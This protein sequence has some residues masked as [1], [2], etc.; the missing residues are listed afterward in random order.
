MGGSTFDPNMYRSSA[1][2]S[3]ASLGKSTRSTASTS[4]AK[5]NTIV[6]RLQ[7]GHKNKAGKITRES[8]DSDDKPETVAVAVFVDV[9]GSNKTIADSALKYL[10]TLMATLTLE[11][12]IPG[13]HVLFGAVDDYKYI[14]NR[15]LQIGQFEGGLEVASDLSDLV[16][17]AMGGGNDV[18]SYELPMYFMAKYAEMD[19]YEKRGKKGYFFMIADE[20]LPSKLNHHEW[21]EL[22]GFGADDPGRLHEDI[23]IKQVAEM[24]QEK[25]TVCIIYPTENEYFRTMPSFI[26]SWRDVFGEAVYECDKVVGIVPFITGLIG[27]HEG[28]TVAEITAKMKTSDGG[29][30]AAIDAAHTSLTKYEAQIGKSGTQVQKWDVSDPDVLAQTK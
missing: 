15:A 21:N 14:R 13:P 8:R 16:I 7:A 29:A 2:Y 4:A 20:G 5:S 10:P 12:V 28:L 27:M 25:F 3:A 17:T 30:T 19:C 26:Q 11:K 18:E 22:M 1:L 6:D 9:T 23:P 24:L